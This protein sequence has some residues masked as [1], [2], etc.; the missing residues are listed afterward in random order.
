M[1]MTIAD[2]RNHFR[3]SLAAEDF[4]YDRGG[5]KTIE[6]L[7]ASFI[8]DEPTIIGTPN[9]EYIQAELDW[10]VSQ[11]TNINDI[12]GDDRPAPKAWQHTANA[13]GEINSNYG[14]LIWSEQNGRQFDRVF[15]ELLTNPY[16]RRAEMVYQRP[17]IWEDYRAQGKNDFICTNAV[18]YYVREQQLHAVVQMRSNDVVFGY[19]NDYAWQKYV[20]D[21]LVSE[22]R[23]FADYDN[24]FD[25]LNAGDIIWQVQ[26]LHIYERHFGLLK[27]T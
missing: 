10:Y 3:E 17:T 18:T 4:T 22:L 20:Q 6:L 7:G 16:S 23:S 8:A 2:I 9:E 11:S 14:H 15:N 26:N 5:S 25:L 21:L 24:D 27:D 1:Y 19:K 13:H 12:Y